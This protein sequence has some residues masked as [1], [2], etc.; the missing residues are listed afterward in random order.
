MR[1]KSNIKL[2]KNKYFPS[3]TYEVLKNGDVDNFYI[4]FNVPYIEYKNGLP[5]RIRIN[6]SIGNFK[7]DT[8]FLKEVQERFESLIRSLKEYG[9]KA[10]TF[11]AVVHW[12]LVVGLGATH[13]QEVSMTLHHI[14]GFPYIPAS[15]IKGITRHWTLLKFADKK[16][17]TERKNFVD[18]VKEVSSALENGN[19]MALNVEGVSFGDLIKIFGTQRRKGEVIFMDAYPLGKIKLKLDIMNPHYP[20]YYGGGEP[21]ADWQNPNPIKF[22]TVERTKFQFTLLSQDVELLKKTEKLLKE[23][24]KEHGIGAKTS[25]GYGIFEI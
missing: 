10:A 6:E 1:E 25:L 9:F 18:C 17:K 22:L 23:A 12:R 14:Y 11:S 15:A 2:P 21:P 7:W 5:R 13:P 20:D 24:L 19:D 3:D 16:R 8:R 4:L